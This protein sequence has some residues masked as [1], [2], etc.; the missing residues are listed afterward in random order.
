M[1]GMENASSNGVVGAV[2][3]TILLT[4]NGRE[5]SI[6]IARLLPGQFDQLLA[7]LHVPIRPRF[8]PIAGSIHAQQLAGPALAQMKSGRDERNVLSQTGK[9]QPFFRMTASAL[10]CPDSDPQL[11]PSIAGSHLPSAET[12][13]FAHIESA[14]RIG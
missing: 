9:L 11:A 5:A 1:E 8:V 6:S 2:I 13:R 3:F 14:E 4:I 7:Q 12:L 10:P